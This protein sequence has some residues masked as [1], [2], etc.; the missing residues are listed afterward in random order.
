MFSTSDY[1]I[2]IVEQT[3]ALDA[4]HEEIKLLSK[5]TIE[6][7]KEKYNYIHFWLVQITTKLLI[8]EKLDTSMFLCLRDSRFLEFN[9]SLIGMAENSFCGGLVHFDFIFKLYSLFKRQKYFR[10][11]DLTLKLLTIESR[12]GLF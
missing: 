3:I 6:K 5:R 9:D 11:F 4:D 12:L 8:R 2:K 7:Y 1:T 10:C